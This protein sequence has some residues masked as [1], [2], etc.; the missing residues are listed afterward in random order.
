MNKAATETDQLNTIKLLRILKK[1]KKQLLQI[2]VA[3]AIAGF[4]ITL[5]FIMKPMYK[6]S[7]VLYPANLSPYSKETPT[8]QMVQLLSS[9][10]VRDSLVKTFHLYKHYGI[11]SVNGY[12]WY[13]MMKRMDDNISVGKNQYE[14][15]EVAVF[16]EDP[17][18]AQQLCA[19][20]IH[21]MDQKAKSLIH[22]RALEAASV[23]KVMMDHE[24]LILDSLDEQMTTI[25]K[26]YGITDFE[27]QV[28]SFAR[29]YYRVM[30]GGGANAKMAT[31][32][33]NFEEKGAEY[34]FLKET[35]WRVRG[36]YNDYR[37]N[38]E[39]AINDAQK[40]LD[41][42]NTVSPPLVPEKKDSPKRAL[43]MI[44]FSLSV[45]LVAVIVIVYQEQYR[46]RLLQQLEA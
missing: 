6:S 12:P 17:K 18:M 27:Q 3:S 19:G 15:I 8:E 38:Y 35:L 2:F 31:M 26:E 4:I 44:M 16:D 25:R 45:M 39:T 22:I 43:I 7:A 32:Q 36:T 9:E 29:E 46:D 23:N 5:P 21:F 11:D 28:G 10:D 14:A 24:K 1:W 37:K 34:M 42:H 30:A 33:K 13:E 20:L 41:F 40:D